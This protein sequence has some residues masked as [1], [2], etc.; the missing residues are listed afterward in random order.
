[1]GSIGDTGMC[2]VAIAD[3]NHVVMVATDGALD[4]VGAVVGSIVF[5]TPMTAIELPM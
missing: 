5:A 3:S 2:V 1:M 4:T